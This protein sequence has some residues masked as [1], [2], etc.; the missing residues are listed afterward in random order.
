M[1]FRS[2]LYTV[3]AQA[4]HKA[5]RALTR[6]FGEVEN[7]QVS[8]KGPADFVSNADRKAERIVVEELQKARPNYGFL[9][10]EQGE[11]VGSDISN[12][13]LVD[14]LDGTLNFLHGIPQFAVSIALERDRRIE[15]GV[16]YNPITDDLYFAERGKGAYHNDRRMR[17]SGRTDFSECLFA[18][19]IPFLGRPGHEQFIRELELVMA[20]SAGVRR[21]GAAAL[22]LAFV[23]AG[24]F[25]GFWERGLQTWDV[26]AGMLLVREAGGMVTDIDGGDAMLE[27]GEIVASNANLDREFLQLLKQAK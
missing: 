23:A 8:R 17:V 18:T 1:N 24:R 25:D 14:P 13:W 21:M 27:T 20:K 10:E 2:P 16:V 7:L 4:A 6:D 3:M 5:G 15:A 11:I 9:L 12:R 22:D 26:A 19:G